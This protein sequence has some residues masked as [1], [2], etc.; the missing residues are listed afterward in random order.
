[1]YLEQP[2]ELSRLTCTVVEWS[3]GAQPLKGVVLGAEGT[4]PDAPL[5]V[6]TQ[7]PPHAP[8]HTHT[9]THTHTP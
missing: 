2:A 4:P 7:V 9:H 3:N 1:M 8:P 5:L 6:S